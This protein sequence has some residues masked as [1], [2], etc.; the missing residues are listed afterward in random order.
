M[1]VRGFHVYHVNWKPVIGEA[2]SFFQEPDN[3]Y[4]CCAVAVKK[5]I[6]DEVIGH[7][8]IEISRHIFYAIQYGCVFKATVSDDRHHRSPITQGGLEIK[9]AV[10]FSWEV[11]QREKFF[12]LKDYISKWYDFQTSLTQDDSDQILERLEEDMK[13]M[14]LDDGE[15][16]VN[17]ETIDIDLIDDIE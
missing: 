5:D 1:G 11:S 4:D 12:L 3:I 15:I 17:D 9:V 13:K 16:N 7:V 2:L 8:P 10:T 14:N 6:H